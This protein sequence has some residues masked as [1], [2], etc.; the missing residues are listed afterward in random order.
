MII[1]YREHRAKV[2]EG[3]SAKACLAALGLPTDHALAAIRGGMVYE[4]NCPVIHGG[5]LASL[6]LSH[7]E[8]RRIYERSIRFVL[9][10]ALRRMLPTQRVRLEYSAGYGVYGFLPGLTVTVALLEALT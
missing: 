2:A 9:L 5:E 1:T 6:T 4:L 3:T 10:L 8:G 7:E